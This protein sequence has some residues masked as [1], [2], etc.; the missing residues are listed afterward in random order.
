MA[1]PRLE[2]AEYWALRVLV[3]FAVLLAASSALFVEWVMAP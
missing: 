3:S 1:S 2:T